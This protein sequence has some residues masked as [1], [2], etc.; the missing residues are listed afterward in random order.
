MTAE[1]T[2]TT[3]TE[4]PGVEM[5]CIDKKDVITTDGRNVGELTGAYIDT[6]TWKVNGLVLEV[7]KDVMDELNMKKPL[8]RTPKAMIQTSLVRV[9]SDTVQLNVPIA[10]L[11]GNLTVVE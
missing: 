1:T 8:L 2:T 10:N 7:N 4:G 11:S 6:S 9:V 3:T 5:G